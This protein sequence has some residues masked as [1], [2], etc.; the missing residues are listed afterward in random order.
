MF[1]SNFLNSSLDLGFSSPAPAEDDDDGLDQPRALGTAKV[2]LPFSSTFL[3]PPFSPAKI[4]TYFL[5]NKTH[6]PRN[7]KWNKSSKP[8]IKA[9]YVDPYKREELL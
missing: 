3:S 6:I 2:F 1:R 4:F 7:Q 5:S 8:N 9:G